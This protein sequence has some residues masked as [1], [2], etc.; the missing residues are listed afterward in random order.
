MN[1]VKEKSDVKILLISTV[2][3]FIISLAMLFYGIYMQVALHQTKA[4]LLLGILAGILLAIPLEL[5]N[6]SDPDTLFRVMAF[7]DRFLLVCFG[8]AIGLGAILL[9]GL[10]L[11]VP[12][13]NFGIKDFFVP[14]IV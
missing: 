1:Q 13:P 3:L 7:Q 6:F 9:Y 10:Y 11:F 2:I 8:F 12:N 14:G 5:W 4:P